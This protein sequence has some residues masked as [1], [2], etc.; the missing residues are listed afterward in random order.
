LQD[1][2]PY[3]VYDSAGTLLLAWYQ[4]SN[5]VL[6]AGDTD[7]AAPTVV[8]HVGSASSAKDFRL[9]TGPDGQ[10]SILWVDLAED[11]TGPDPFMLNYDTALGLW[12]EPVRMLNNTDLLERS[13]TGAYAT[14]G[15]LLMAYNQ[16]HVQRDTNGVPVFTNSSV[17]LMFLEYLISGDLGL[18]P[19]DISFSTNSP[20]PGQSVDIF[21]TV[22]NYGELAA[23]NVAVAFF[24]GDPASGGTL[25][26]STQ[27]V[28]QIVA[29][30]SSNVTVSWSVP[31]PISET[32][33]FVAVDPALTQDDRNRANNV[34]S[35]VALMPDLSVS[36]MSVVN[37]ATTRRMVNARILNQGGASSGQGFDVQFR[38]GSTNG[39]LVGTAALDALPSSG[40][41]DANVEWDMSGETFTTAYESVYAVADSGGQIAEGDKGNNIALVQV[42]TTLDSDSDGLLDGEELRYGT[43]IGVE[44]SDGDGLKDGEEVNT[45][46][47]APIVS[48]SDGD[49]M[50]DGDEVVAGTDPNSEA[51]VFAITGVNTLTGLTEVHWSAKSNRTYQVLKSAELLSWTNAPSGA[52]PD[53]QSRQTA[54][55]N[56]VLYYIDPLSVTN[57]KA[58]YRVNVEDE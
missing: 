58:F 12:S 10:V 55:T 38:R 27:M 39:A 7:L 49:G 4:G 48:D 46:G 8:G 44:D 21:A 28:A 26:G 56:G 16:V 29:G 47:T 40:Q 41:F 24:N 23:T 19:T 9:V 31:D 32:T 14:N 20:L 1:T 22:R 18:S 17:D 2:K 33:V 54:A 50:K 3:A 52:G 51:D 15:A 5:V 36:E 45:Y 53:E 57:G 30:G 34:V 42:M 37:S 13:F 43:G 11:G 35:S 25:I 6:R